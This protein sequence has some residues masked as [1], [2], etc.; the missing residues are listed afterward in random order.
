[1][2]CKKLALLLVGMA[3]VLLSV[4]SPTVTAARN[5]VMT[6]SI[7]NIRNPLANLFLVDKPAENCIPSRSGACLAFPPRMLCL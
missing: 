4:M 3:A 5:E 1:M 2:E 6:F 7:I